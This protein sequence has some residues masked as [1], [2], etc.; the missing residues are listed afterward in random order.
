MHGQDV[1]IAQAKVSRYEKSNAEVIN[2]NKA[3]KDTKI[4]EEREKLADEVFERERMR[5]VRQE[6]DMILR[7][8]KRQ[9]LKETNAVS[10]QT[11]II[12]QY[13]KCHRCSLSNPLI[14]FH[15]HEIN[16]FE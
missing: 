3:L 8:N 5:L 4:K 7:E 1:E 6:E 2:Q 10:G 13:V 15:I 14:C 12:F 9:Q 11:C 16:D